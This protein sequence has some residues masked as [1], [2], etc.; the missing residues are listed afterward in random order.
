[1]IR[2]PDELRRLC[3]EHRRAGRR[4]GFVPTM[5]YL[6]E[7]HL[8][9]MR[10]AR[11]AAEVVVVSIFVNPTQFGPSED[12]SRYPRDLEGDLAKC[13]S[14]PVDLV[15]A[16]EPASV[17]PPGFQTVV[18]VEGLSRGLCGERRPGHFRGV[19]TVV[20]KL[21]CL[22]GPCTAVFGEKDFQ[23]LLVIRQ[24]ARDLELPVTVVGAPI[25]REPDGL[26]LSSRNAYLSPAE[27]ASAPCL[28]RALEEVARAAAAAG[29]LPASAALAAVERELAGQGVATR[30]DYV[31]ARDARTLA[32]RAEL[33]PDGQTLV[34]LAVFFGKT[35]LIDNLV[36]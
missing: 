32:P 14:I 26:A 27:R 22:V 18:E 7:G 2:E 8:S 1:M 9:L 16:P 20:T 33:L 34:A 5:G 4:I 36:F 10:R 6:H 15:Y 24:L 17:Y 13:A 12:L 29:R 21:L 11:E 23:Q 3:D 28:H 30:I 25:V 35:R 19:A 31:E